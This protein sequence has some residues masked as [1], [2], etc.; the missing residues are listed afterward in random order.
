MSKYRRRKEGL[1]LIEVMLAL[2]ILG[3]GL[4]VMIAT[5]SKCLAVVRQ[6][7]NYE[8]ARELLAQVEL[9]HPILL[10]EIEAGTENGSFS[11]E[12]SA[13]KWQRNIEVV[14]EEEEDGLFSVA[15][16]V[17]WAERGRESYEEVVTYVYAPEEKR[18]GTVESGP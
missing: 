1:T 9:D 5:A 14:G 2:A 18:G 4:F 15:T 16:R 13:Y 10:E 7:R 6:S 12:D 17:S 11:G 3:I 8:K